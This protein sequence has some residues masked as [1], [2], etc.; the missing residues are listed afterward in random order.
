MGTIFILYN[1][2]AVKIITDRSIV[3]RKV[4]PV[5][6]GIAL[7]LAIKAIIFR[8]IIEIYDLFQVAFIGFFPKQ[9]PVAVDIRYRQLTIII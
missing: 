9:L 3:Y 6:I 1:H 7:W 5:A 4:W 2:I 8:N